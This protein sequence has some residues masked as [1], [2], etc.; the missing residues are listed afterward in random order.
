M[1]MEVRV[2]HG[3]RNSSG[4]EV[5]AGFRWGF[6][7]SARGPG[8]CVPQKHVILEIGAGA[9]NPASH[10]QN[11][12]PGFGGARSFARPKPFPPLNCKAC[13]QKASFHSSMVWPFGHPHV[14]RKKGNGFLSREIRAPLPPRISTQP[15]CWRRAGD[16]P[17]SFY[18]AGRFYFDQG[19]GAKTCFFFQGL[20]LGGKQI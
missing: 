13:R 3:T 16:Y 9:H 17:N 18:W 19:A 1:R 4:L 10:H 15:H 7:V 5:V 20:I 11:Y 6:M 2:L 12:S 14:P 8:I